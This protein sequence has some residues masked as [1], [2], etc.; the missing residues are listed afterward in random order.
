MEKC[1]NVGSCACIE[2]CIVYISGEEFR[3]DMDWS[4]TWEVVALLRRPGAGGF[5]HHIRTRC[6][7]I[8]GE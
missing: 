4:S 2:T 6:S 7:S 1:E 3:M 8:D 5:S